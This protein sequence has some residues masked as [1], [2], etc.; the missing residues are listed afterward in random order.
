V[1]LV[2]PSCSANVPFTGI[3]ACRSA[4]I[5]YCVAETAFPSSP[6]RKPVKTIPPARRIRH[7]C[8]WIVANRCSRLRETF[9]PPPSG[10]EA[11]LLIEI[12]PPFGFM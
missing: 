10:F 12:I 7:R 9:P 4:F 1:R 8:L 2:L 3:S 6:A 5:P 11:R